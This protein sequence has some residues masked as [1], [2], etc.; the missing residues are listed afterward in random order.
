MST[1]QQSRYTAPHIPRWLD[2]LTIYALRL[3]QGI[4]GRGTLIARRVCKIWTPAHF[5]TL[6]DFSAGSCD[7]PRGIPRLPTTSQVGSRGRPRGVAAS[8]GIAHGMSLDVAGFH[9]NSPVNY[10]GNPPW[11]PMSF[12]GIPWSLGLGLGFGFSRELA[13]SRGNLLDHARNSWELV[14][15]RGNSW[16]L[17]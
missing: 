17:V 5:H 9:G 10:R 7:F 3:F 12:L 8:R 11:E 13:K 14:G 1:I 4:R 15:T 6:V 16:E 2:G